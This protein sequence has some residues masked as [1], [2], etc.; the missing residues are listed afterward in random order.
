MLTV[1]AQT[2]DQVAEGLKQRSIVQDLSPM[3]F[4][5]ELV[6]EFEVLGPQGF[7]PLGMEVIIMPLLHKQ[8]QVSSKVNG[9]HLQ[10]HIQVTRLL[11]QP[12]HT[13]LHADHHFCQTSV[14][15]TSLAQMSSVMQSI[16]IG[17]SQR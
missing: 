1:P 14:S 16:L 17:R 6:P 2:N 8:L 3:A 12:K 13:R 9:M 15:C 7:A 10:D 5:H 4:T 11:Q